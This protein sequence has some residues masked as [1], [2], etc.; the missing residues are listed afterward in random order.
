MRRT[1]VLAALAAAL[2]APVA[3]ALPRFGVLV[4]GRSLAGVRL[5]DTAASVKGRL[6]RFYGTCRACSVPTLYFTYKPFTQQ[7]LAVELR[8]GRVAAVYTLWEPPLWR[9]SSGLRLGAPERTVPV[10][11]A[12][13][14]SG[15]NAFV[16]TSR[17]V[18]TAYY[19]VDGKLWGFGLLRPG[20]SVCR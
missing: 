14:C 16:A 9:T 8:G 1:L 12:V 18:Q 7:G 3:Q 5:G 10:L 20:L 6:G 4:P 2:A 11:R 19:V 15:Y 13:A 17:R